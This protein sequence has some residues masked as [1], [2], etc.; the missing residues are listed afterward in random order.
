MHGQ[1][2]FKVARVTLFN[3]FIGS[4]PNPSRFIVY[5]SLPQN[6]M[7]NA[8]IFY[9]VVLRKIKR[10]KFTPTDPEGP[11]KKKSFSSTLS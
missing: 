8:Q 4:N 3:L 6:L 1:Q 7:H 11:K 10:V 9:S 5:A 2:N